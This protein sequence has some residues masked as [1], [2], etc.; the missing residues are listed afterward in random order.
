MELRRF[1]VSPSAVCGGSVV[2]DGGEFIHM[3]KVLRMKRGFKVVVCP[4]DGR[5]LYCTVETVE[6]DRAR[7][8]IDSERTVDR[9]GADV[10]L[11][12]GLL[13]NQKTDWVVQ[14]AVELGV[15]TI[16]PFVSANTVE[17]KFNAERARRIALEAGKQC[18]T[19]YISEVRDAVDFADVLQESAQYT[20]VLFA[21]EGERRNS[22][23]NV[24][25]KGRKIAL[26]VG[27]EGGFKESERDA[28]AERGA[29][30]V[31]LGRRILRAETADIVLSA[32][33]LDALGELDYD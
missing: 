26:I 33:T 10:T 3:T 15:D 23:R 25:F 1:F 19:A 17:R 8:R 5:E 28:A 4:N 32:L 29:V 20:D 11:Y 22:V 12:C 2:I 13:K 6:S 9:R 24:S 7:L 27:S 18:G 30:T 14:K 21:Y 16:V 31:T